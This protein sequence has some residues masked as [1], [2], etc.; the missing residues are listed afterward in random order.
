MVPVLHLFLVDIIDKLLDLILIVSSLKMNWGFCRL[1]ELQFLSK[2]LLLKLL[3]Q[4]WDLKVFSVF[5]RYRI[6]SLGDLLNI[7]SILLFRFLNSRKLG[8]RLAH[9]WV[10]ALSV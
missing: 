3:R 6:L 10:G 8:L 9:L 5:W 4:L 7:L 1:L 2:E